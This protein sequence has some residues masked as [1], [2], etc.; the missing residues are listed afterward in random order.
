MATLLD[1]LEHGRA[2]APALL[3]PDGP[4]LT[5]A[6]LRAQVQR[7]AGTLASFGLRRQDRVSLALPNGA[8]CVVAFLATAAVATAAPLNPNYTEAEFRFYME[9]TGA[10]ALVVP[11]G[12]GEAARQALPPG[13]IL[14]EAAF[15]ESGDLRLESDAPRQPGRTASTPDPDDVALVLHTSGTT[16]RPKR[17]PLRHRNLAASLE[18]IVATYALTP[19]DVSLCVM[20]QFHV[21]GLM[22]STLSTLRSGGTVVVPPRFNPLGFW[23]VAKE[24]RATWYSAVPTIHQLLLARSRDGTRPE[25]SETLRFIR[26]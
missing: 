26:S 18:N 3:V 21:H 17:V 7:A 6:A 19:D 15:D 4:R 2:D 20:P 16:S 24:Y 9:D 13:A 10:R 5:Y 23:P 11:P 14:I 12:G 22:A 8:E 25:G 1:A